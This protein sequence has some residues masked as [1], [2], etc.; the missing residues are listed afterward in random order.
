MQSFQWFVLCILGLIALVGVHRRFTRS[1]LIYR[2]LDEDRTAAE[3]E[4]IMC[5]Y[6]QE[7][8]K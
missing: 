4:K 5:A 2:L 8:E 3:I 6:K 7:E 1:K